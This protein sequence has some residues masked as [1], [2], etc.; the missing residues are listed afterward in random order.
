MTA[1]ALPTLKTVRTSFRIRWLNTPPIRSRGG[2]VAVVG[3]GNAYWECTITTPSSLTAE[4][5]STLQAWFD[6]LEGGLNTFLAHDDHRP[7]PVAYRAPISNPAA[8]G[9]AGL[10]K[11]DNVTPFVGLATCS[12]IAARQITITALPD[13]FVFNVGDYIGLVQSSKYSLHRVTGA[14][15]GDTSGVAA[16]VPVTPPINLN[17]YST[18]A[19]VNLDHPLAEFVPDPDSWS[20]DTYLRLIPNESVS[21]SGISRVA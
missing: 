1:Y 3:Y 21:F 7:Y 17:V 13:N 18:S 19:V 16:N 14:V 12:A 5:V 2:G 20:G 9:F 4:E 15:T 6:K 11:Q 8:N 10:L